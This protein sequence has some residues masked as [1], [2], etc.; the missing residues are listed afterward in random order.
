M[1]DDQYEEVKLHDN[2]DSFS[3]G[4]KKSLNDVSPTVFSEAYP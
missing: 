2:S 4:N 1:N 3:P